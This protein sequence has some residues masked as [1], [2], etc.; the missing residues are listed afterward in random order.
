[1]NVNRVVSPSSPVDSPPHVYTR[2]CWY[3]C[4]YAYGYWQLCT[5]C[6]PATHRSKLTGYDVAQMLGI[7]LPGTFRCVFNAFGLGLNLPEGLRESSLSSSVTCS[8]ESNCEKRRIR[9]VSSSFLDLRVKNSST[10]E[11]GGADRSGTAWIGNP[12]VAFLRYER[13]YSS[14]PWILESQGSR[15]KLSLTSHGLVK[16]GS[17]NCWQ[18]IRGR[19]Y[20]SR[21]DRFEFHERSC[22][23][24]LCHFVVSYLRNA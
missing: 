10:N 16:H 3:T 19:S 12:P 24:Q 13:S 2:L 20:R 23:R 5:W 15:S 14:R 1:M 18:V 17:P 22:T 21:F 6:S 11:T 8:N 4:T 7:I 9:L